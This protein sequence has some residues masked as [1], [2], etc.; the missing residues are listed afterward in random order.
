MIPFPNKY[1]DFDLHLF[2]DKIYKG[3][4]LAIVKGSI[5]PEQSTLVRVHSQCLTGDIFGSLRCDCGE[6]LALALDEIDRSDSG[7]CVYL[8]QEGRGIGLKN[9][10]LS[11]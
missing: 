4:H 8:R 7:I 5:N 2:E 9:K 3:N 10:I 11:Y 1:G 6:Q